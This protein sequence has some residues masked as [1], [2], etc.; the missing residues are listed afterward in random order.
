[1]IMRYII[2]EKYVMKF[3]EVVISKVIF[4]GEEGTI[5]LMIKP[6]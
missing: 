4:I 3:L 2:Y 1:M 6:K 5:S